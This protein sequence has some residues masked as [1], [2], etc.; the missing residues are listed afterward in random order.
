MQKRQ[1]FLIILF[2]GP[3]VIVGGCV[4]AAIG[5]G[6]GTVAYVRGDLEVVESENLDSVY[7]AAEKAIKELGL[8]TS[9]R[10]KD[11]MSAEITARDSEDKKI[12][13]KLDATAEGTTKLS[14]RVGIF[15]NET[16]SRLIYDQIKKNL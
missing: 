1:I 16:K 8:T 13:I 6:A 4:V 2:V 9:R 10:T 5:A 14:I 12:K 7:N 15:G 11:A 3:A